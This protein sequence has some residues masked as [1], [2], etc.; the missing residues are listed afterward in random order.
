[1]GLGFG[2]ALRGGVEL[3]ENGVEKFPCFLCFVF[4]GDEEP[5][6]SGPGCVGMNLFP[7]MAKVAV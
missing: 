5:E 3:G 7:F 1:L 6:E 2:Y 4:L